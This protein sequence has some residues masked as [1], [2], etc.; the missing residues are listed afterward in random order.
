M[1]LVVRFDSSHFLRVREMFQF[2]HTTWERVMIEWNPSELRVHFQGQLHGRPILAELG[3]PSAKLGAGPGTV[4]FTKAEFGR[5]LSMSKLTP[6]NEL[7][8]PTG[9]IAAVS[10]VLVHVP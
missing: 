4:T 6:P 2:A 10:L 1:G 5:M 9:T 7:H 8:A 3:I